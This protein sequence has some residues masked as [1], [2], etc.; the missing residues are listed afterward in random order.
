VFIEKGLNDYL[1]NNPANEIIIGESGFGTGLNALLTLLYARRNRIKIH[2]QTYEKYPLSP[3]IIKQLAEMFTDE[4]KKF[5]LKIHE[6]NW[7][8]KTSITE[9][10]EIE[11]IQKDFVRISAKD[12]WHVHYY[13]AF[14]PRV[15][16][17][18]WEKPVLKRIYEGLRAGGFFVT[19]SAKGSV[20]RNLIDLGF[21]VEKLAG[22]PGKREMLRARKPN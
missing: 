19:Y 15:Q 10:F 22:P 17:G 5:F 16:P 14:S 13:D 20:R 2:Y 21:E 9:Y 6:A 11:K 3:E 8:E 1:K 12:L 18:L 7:E 4:E